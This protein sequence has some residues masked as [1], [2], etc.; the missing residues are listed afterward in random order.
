MDMP[1]ADDQFDAVITN[2]SLHEWENP[3]MVFNEIY[4]VL[5]N[6]GRFLVTDLKRN[7]SFPI[8]YFMK[9]YTKPKSMK[10]GFTSSLH[11]AYTAEEIRKIV[12]NTQFNITEVKSDF[13]GLSISG[14]KT[15]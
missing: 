13:F 2:G 12:A 10:K 11:A 15:V 4:R 5:K 1:F 3:T 6:G 14:Q 7:I 8:Q 9:A